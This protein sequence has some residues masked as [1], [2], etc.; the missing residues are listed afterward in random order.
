MKIFS[1]KRDLTRKE[2]L[3]MCLLVVNVLMCILTF[4]YLN[5]TRVVNYQLKTDETLSSGTSLK[6]FCF[7]TFKNILDK[8]FSVNALD[9]LVY[10]TLL[11]D[12]DFFEFSESER[13][14]EV[15]VKTDQCKIITTGDDGLRSFLVTTESNF[16]NPLYNRITNINEEGAK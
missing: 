16:N 13:I 3:M 12:P 14:T 10:K 15:V 1:E 8:K 7:Y 9:S 5:S 4:F 2:K 6:N 11:N